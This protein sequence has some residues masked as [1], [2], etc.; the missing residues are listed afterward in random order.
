MSDIEEIDAQVERLMKDS[1]YSEQGAIAIV[2]IA[3]FRSFTRRLTT[4]SDAEPGALELI[5]MKLGELAQEVHE[6]ERAIERYIEN[7]EERE[8]R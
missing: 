2:A 6:A 3:N 5:G 1:G 4:G 7:L 8:A